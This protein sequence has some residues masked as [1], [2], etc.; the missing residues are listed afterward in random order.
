MQIFQLEYYLPK[1]VN[2]VYLH[3]YDWLPE[4]S[5]ELASGVTIRINEIFQEN[6]EW[7]FVR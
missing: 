7:Y 6:N 1:E 4:K 3:N 5:K 2:H